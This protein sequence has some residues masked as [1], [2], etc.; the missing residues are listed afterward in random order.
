MTF[1]VYGPGIQ[2][3]VHLHSLFEK[4]R[5]EKVP[6]TIRMHPVREKE[7]PDETHDV[8]QN[9]AK[10]K[11]NLK[12]AHATYQSID[13]L[14]QDVP[15]LFANQI[16]VSPVITLTTQA[17]IDEAIKLFQEKQIRHMPVLSLQGAL[18]GMISERDILR[19]LGG[20]SES[21][22]QRT[23]Q[24]AISQPVTQLMQPRVLTASAETDVRY[25]ARLFVDRRVG[26]MPIVT[27]GK[28]VGIITRSDIL[29]AVMGHFELELWA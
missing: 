15:A 6:E 3:P 27:A 4:R 2:D 8:T 28:L 5:A 11:T 12:I 16:M 13:K 25:I 20:V 26:A 21:Y 9:D 14:P 10:N 17:V 19:Y 29:R 18:Q 22:E 1:T 7:Y 23:T 24:G